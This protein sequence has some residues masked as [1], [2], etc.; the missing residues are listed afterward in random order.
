[1]G[2]AGPVKINGSY[3]NKEYFLPLATLEGAL[4]ASYN[5]GA[6]V[7]SLS[8]GA[9]T[10]FHSC[11]VTRVPAFKLKDSFTAKDFQIWLENLHENK[12][13]DDLVA[14][15]SNYCKLSSVKFSELANILYLELNFST[16]NAAGQNMVTLASQ[17]IHD[18]IMANSP[19]DIKRSMVESNF[20]SDKKASYRSLLGV[21]G[22][23]VSAEVLIPEAIVNEYLLKIW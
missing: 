14:S 13:F 12:V 18:Y 4:V 2:I 7:I 21:R 5:R 6:K 10:V 11:A 20:S 15:T 8:G 16:G 3:A 23:K 1:M 17:A 19:F 9:K 22:A